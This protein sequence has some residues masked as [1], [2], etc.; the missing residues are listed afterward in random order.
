MLDEDIAVRVI[1]IGAKLYVA[2]TAIANYQDSTAFVTGLLTTRKTV[3]RWNSLSKSRDGISP[4]D[5]SDKIG[6]SPKPTRSE[7]AKWISLHARAQRR[8]SASMGGYSIP[9]G[10]LRAGG[11]SFQQ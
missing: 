7:V 8:P 2:P 4:H 11:Q 9:S 6:Y 10:T 1:V 3:W 5:R